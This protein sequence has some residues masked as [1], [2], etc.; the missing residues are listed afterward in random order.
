MKKVTIIDYG[1]GNVFSVASA[2][3]QAGAEVSLSC[4]PVT[5]AKSDRVILPGVGAFA[6]GMAELRQRNLIPSI[7]K[8]V[9]GEKPF[10]GICLGMQMLFDTTEEFGKHDG[11]GIIEG[12]VCAI[13]K[14]KSDGSSRKIP[15]IGWNKVTASSPEK[16]KDPILN[17]IEDNFFSYFVHSFAAI[18]KD[19]DVRVADC[20]YDGYKISALV[21]KNYIW[22]SQ[23]HPEKSST[24]GLSI[25]NNFLNI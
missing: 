12:D 15:H 1:M 23:F 8:F 13:P 16:R 11:L 6:D 18:P 2:F 20:D 22:G 24:L 9:S 21:R 4:D 19:S 7:H 14:T 5:I 3:E 17:G 10:M 25:V